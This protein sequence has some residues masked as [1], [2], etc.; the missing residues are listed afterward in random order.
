MRGMPVS[1]SV[2]E[3]GSDFHLSAR[4]LVGRPDMGQVPPLSGRHSVFLASGRDAIHWII[5]SLRLPRGSQILLPAYLCEDVVKPFLG[6]GMNV[7]FYRV[8]E[9]LQADFADLVSKLSPEVRV[10]IYIHYFGFPQQLPPAIIESVGPE[11]ILVE[12]SSHA[13]LSCLDY[14]PVR[15]DFRFASYRKLLPIPNGGIVSWDDERLQIVAPVTTSLS[16]S[17]MGS[18]SCRCLGMALKALW[19]KTPRI[20]PKNL[21]R[22]LFSWSTTLLDVYPKP[23]SMSLI[24]RYLLRRLD[25]Q[26]I[27]KTRRS[28][29]QFLLD[30][31]NCS[32]DPRPL[33]TSL[34]DGVCPLGFPLLV[35]DRD[36]LARHLIK[37]RVYSPIHWELP[38]AVDK[39]EFHEAWTISDHILTI[40]L[41]QRY[42]EED[43]ARILEVINCYE[44][45]QAACPA[46]R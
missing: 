6:K 34:P 1:G 41:D 14:L 15:G 46:G 18:L 20:Y 24:S 22:Q 8:D 5:Q 19:L 42:D 2:R 44:P 10:L 17:Y 7:R 40:P 16:M 25:L 29:F 13:I 11:T 28:N 43:M 32:T 31:L 4:S 45:A 30:S 12:D 37:H 23:A 33:Y 21:F 3:I 26:R 9:N 38:E 27:I 36:G 39:N 35:D